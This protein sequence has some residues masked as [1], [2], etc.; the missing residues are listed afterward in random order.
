M[1]ES[2]P[3]S[4]QQALQ[5]APQQSR[6]IMYHVHSSSSRLRFLKLAGG[7][8]CGF[9][10]LPKLS[11]LLDEEPQGKL[12]QH[13]A[14]FAKEAAENLGL[15]ADDLE[16]EGEYRAW[17]DVPNGPVQVF[18]ARFTGIDPPFAAAEAHGAEFVELPQARNL[19]PTELLLL[20]KAYELVIGG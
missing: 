19:P 3:Q 1:Q 9:D 18:L 2:T 14:A 5:Q 16:I 11:S 6:L 15:S 8:I 12:A 20:R 10:P 7:N 4:P 13:P 17:V